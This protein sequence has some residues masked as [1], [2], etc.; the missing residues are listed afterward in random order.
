MIIASFKKIQV[1]WVFVPSWVCIFFLFGDNI[2]AI[3]AATDAFTGGLVI[4]MY[5]K[6]K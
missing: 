2:K 6:P 4:P 3:S 1:I 5:G